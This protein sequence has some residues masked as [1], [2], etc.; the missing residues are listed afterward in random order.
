ML[1]RIVDPSLIAPCGL[2]CGTC[3]FH[4]KEKKPC[5]GCRTG[6]FD[7]PKTRFQCAI[8]NCE[9]L[10][11]N[12]SGFCYDCN[13]FP[14]RDLSRLA[15]RYRTKYHADVLEN[16]RYIKETGL[17]RFMEDERRKWTCIKC[18]GTICVHTG[19]C[20]VCNGPMER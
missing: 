2:N 14:C 16:L 4:L 3:R 1:L 8:R 15:K 13:E 7:R 17:D 20:S 10:K 9:T 11:N 18:Q 6:D 19:L 5:P 12:V